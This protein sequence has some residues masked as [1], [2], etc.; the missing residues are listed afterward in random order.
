MQQINTILYFAR[1]ISGR[2][3]KLWSPIF[4]FNLPT[5]TTSDMLPWFDKYTYKSGPLVD[6]EYL[7]RNS[8]VR[9][10]VGIICWLIY[11]RHL[12]ETFLVLNKVLCISND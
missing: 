6:L 11:R 5:S 7:R 2:R 9:L 1:S 3:I 12:F 10:L 8:A 4:P